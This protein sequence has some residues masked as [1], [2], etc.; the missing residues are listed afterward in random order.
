VDPV[1]ASA[2][3]RRLL[4]N[5]AD[6]V[7]FLIYH[8]NWW[9][10]GC[11]STNHVHPVEEIHVHVLA[12]EGACA[13]NAFNLSDQP[14]VLRAEANLAGWR[15]DAARRERS[16]CLAGDPSGLF[17]GL[18]DLLGEGG[19]GFGWRSFAVEQYLFRGQALPVVGD[20]GIRV[21]GNGTPFY[22]RPAV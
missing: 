17:R 11:L 10:G 22:G 19:C 7:V 13:V 15:L 1:P 12:D 5:C 18:G 6:G 4:A 21:G 16:G 8:G 9:N 20:I 14:R 3:A 2:A